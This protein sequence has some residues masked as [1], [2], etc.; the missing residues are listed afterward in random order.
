MNLKN[1]KILGGVAGA[2]V[3]LIIISIAL[4]GGQT[5]KKQATQIPTEAVIPTVDSSVVVDLKSAGKKGEAILSV[6]NAPAG[7]KA[8]EYTLSYDA[9]GTGEEGDSG[10]I[11]QG[12]IGKCE[13]VGDI[14]ECGEPTTTSKGRK[15]VLGTCSSGVCRYHTI[16]GK[17][18]VE[19][20]FSGS[21]G[22]KAFE[23]EYSL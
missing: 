16:I 8:I 20:K 13:K 6:N 15:I 5:Q 1:K 18:K 19:L 23:K 22:E 7:T 9:Q 4:R 12:A 14:W 2:I 3:L 21:Y 11:P 10:P 17:L